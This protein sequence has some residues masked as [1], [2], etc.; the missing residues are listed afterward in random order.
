[1]GDKRPVRPL[2]EHQVDELIDTLTRIAAT[3]GDKTHVKALQYLGMANI[4]A[5]T[6]DPTQ[7]KK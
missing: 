4:A 1:M 7:I 2:T 3:N 6:F 5:A